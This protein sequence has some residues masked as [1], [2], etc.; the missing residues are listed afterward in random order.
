MIS[1]ICGVTHPEMDGPTLSG[2]TNEFNEHYARLLEEADFIEKPF[3][4]DDLGAAIREVL[5]WRTIA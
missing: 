5:A 3:G 1:R 4:M 2:H